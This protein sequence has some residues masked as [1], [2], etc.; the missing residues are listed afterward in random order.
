MGSRNPCQELD[1]LVPLDACLEGVVG[2]EVGQRA[3]VDRLPEGALSDQFEE[4]ADSTRP[5]E[6][7]TEV[8]PLSLGELERSGGGGNRG[9]GVLGSEGSWR[10]M[11]FWGP[12]E[13][14]MD[15]Y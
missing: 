2:E 10:F 14:H 12:P 7:P 1:D 4:A 5:Q 9:G 3:E 8:D 13:Y 6:L 15:S 11:G